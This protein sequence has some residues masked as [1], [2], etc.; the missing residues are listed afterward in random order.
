MEQLSEE[1][2]TSWVIAPG[3][4]VSP[5]GGFALPFFEFPKTHSAI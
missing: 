4:S 3:G 5:P 2:Q 1:Q